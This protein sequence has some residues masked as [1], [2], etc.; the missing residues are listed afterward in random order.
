MFVEKVPHYHPSLVFI[1]SKIKNL[2]LFFSPQM[3]QSVFCLISTIVL[4][5]ICTFWDSM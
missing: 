5:G 3:C 1:K 4:Y 2:F